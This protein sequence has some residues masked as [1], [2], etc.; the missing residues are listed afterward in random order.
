MKCTDALLDIILNF[1]CY[2]A[3]LLKPL[4]YKV[5]SVNVYE[6]CM[7]MI[8]FVNN[9]ET[10]QDYYSLKNSTLQ[11]STDGTTYFKKHKIHFLSCSVHNNIKQVHSTFDIYT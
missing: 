9:T 3:E 2:S 1:A 4:C 7:G 6:H 5:M 8:S 10:H 11:V